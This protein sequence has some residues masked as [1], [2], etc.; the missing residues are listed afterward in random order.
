MMRGIT[1]VQK[2]SN[3][4]LQKIIDRSI[5]E[6]TIAD[7]GSATTIGVAA[8]SNCTSLTKATLSSSVT[9]IKSKAFDNCTSCLEYD[10]SNLNSVPTLENIDAFTNIPSTSKIWVKSSLYNSYLSASNWSNDAIKYHILD[11]QLKSANLITPTFNLDYCSFQYANPC[12]L[13]GGSFRA[14]IVPNT[15]YDFTGAQVEIIVDGV[16]VSASAFTN[17]EIYIAA[18]NTSLSISVEAISLGTPELTY[19]AVSSKFASTANTDENIAGYYVSGLDSSFSG[20]SVEIPAYHLGKPVWGINSEV[21]KGMTSLTSVTYPKYTHHLYSIGGQAFYNTRLTTIDIPEGV[22][23]I[24]YRAFSSINA[25]SITVPSTVREIGGQAFN[26][27]HYCTR[28]NW[29]VIEI[30][31]SFFTYGSSDAT[32]F[33]ALGKYGNGTEIVFGSKVKTVPRSLFYGT[34]SSGYDYPKIT[35]IQFSDSIISI[36][37]YAFYNIKN[38]LSPVPQLP[39]SLIAIGRYGL[40]NSGM[41]GV[42]PRTTRVFGTQGLS[43]S[44]AT[45]ID[46]TSTIAATTIP[47]NFA[48]SSKLVGVKLHS[49]ITT[50]NSQCFYNCSQLVYFKFPSGLTTLSNTAFSNCANILYYDFSDCTSIPELASSSAFSNIN[51]NCK[52]IIPDSLYAD[53]SVANNWS[54]FASKFITV[55]NLTLT[56][57]SF[58]TNNTLYLDG[59]KFGSY[60]A[61]GYNDLNLDANLL[62]HIVNSDNTKIL[63]DNNNDKV[64]ITDLIDSTKTYSWVDNDETSQANV[65]DTSKDI[66][67]DYFEIISQDGTQKAKVY[68]S[69]NRLVVDG[70]ITIVKWGNITTVSDLVANTWVTYES[71]SLYRY[72]KPDGTAGTSVRDVYHFD[73]VNYISSLTK[74][75]RTFTIDGETQTCDIGMNF[76]EWVDSDYNSAMYLGSKQFVVDGNEIKNRKAGGAKVLFVTLGTIIG[77]S[78]DYSSSLYT[79]LDTPTNV[80]LNGTTLTFNSVENATSYM[81]YAEETNIGESAS[82]S[83]DLTTLT[84]YSNLSAGTYNITVVAKGSLLQGLSLHSSAVSYTI[85]QASPTISDLT[86][87]IWKFNTTCNLF[88]GNV[89]KSWN[90]DFNVN[91]LNGTKINVPQKVGGQPVATC[92]FQ[93]NAYVK[94]TDAVYSSTSQE[95]EGWYDAYGDSFAKSTEPPII[96]IYGGNDATNQDLI[97]WLQSNATQ[98][99]LTD[100]T[101][102]VWKFKDQITLAASITSYH[103]EYQCKDHAYMSGLEF[104]ELNDEYHLVYNYTSNDWDAYV[105]DG[106]VGTW[107]DATYREIFITNGDDVT[108]SNLIDWLF[109]NASF[110]TNDLISF[111][112]ENPY[113]GG[114]N[115]AIT[116]PVSVGTI[117]YAKQGMTWEEFENSPFNTDSIWIDDYNHV[118]VGLSYQLYNELETV[119]ISKTDTITAN[120][121]YH[122]VYCGGGGSN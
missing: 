103:I 36:G 21:F 121:F 20:T 1:N 122:V 120:Y 68:Y 82:N 111:T 101:N 65:L 44:D 42:I 46:I 80:A 96:T 70:T 72:C 54:T 37:E 29:N 93:K 25:T 58:G 13:A 62:G 90:I 63:V 60:L 84:G 117:L 8:L 64:S 91:G 114:G 85:G 71:K 9:T 2:G 77:D 79:R 22:V 119:A 106:I 110:Q 107:G 61:S 17:G 112:I 48:S 50:L 118:F 7:I 69:I 38:T 86:N 31:G 32:K 14:K 100:L 75:Y 81:I 51:A 12:V 11:A 74:E 45:Y 24:G 43:Y 49:G 26:Y 78:S 66:D 108:D 113:S 6:L 94:T 76:G 4:N 34:G 102:T 19:T 10:L 56:P 27:L 83:V 67:R 18:V 95:G 87:T 33:A 23:E 16:D 92:M 57:I 53:W 52:F 105:S 55:S 109:E 59:M 15:N 40:A 28:V 39:K 88:T 3:A 47:D 5:T 30:L 98:I 97:S 35:S 73:K 116:P 89:N 41:G 99:I 104:Y 115:R